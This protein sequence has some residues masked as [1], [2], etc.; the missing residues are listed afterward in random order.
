MINFD[1]DLDL[2]KVSKLLNALLHQANTA[3]I[4]AALTTLGQIGFDT[5]IDKVK[6]KGTAAI[7]TLLDLSDLDN[8]STFASPSAIKA[9]TTQA[10]VTYISN[11]IAS[12]TRIR[13][14]INLTSASTYPVATAANYI[15][16]AQVGNGSGAANAI[17]TGDAW[18][19]AN[20]AS[21]QMGPTATNKVKNGDLVIALTDGATNIDASWLVLQSNVDLATTSIAGLVLLA[22]LAKIQGNAGVDADAVVTVAT[23]NAFLSAPES[24]DATAK[25]V[26]RTKIVQTLT[27]GSNT[28]THNKNTQD[29]LNVLF[30]NASTL[31]FTSMGWTASTVNAIT[32]TRTG[33]SQSFNIFIEY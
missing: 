14:S 12:G 21:F 16:G 30:Q 22:T 33:G 3:T 23:I 10:M 1:D 29:I 7:K 32:V 18:Y 6:I 9:P 8:D 2:G 5:T 24:G 27:N 19:V 17:K 13:G 25:Y 26:K 4:D 31:A 15:N 11:L 28:V 20:A